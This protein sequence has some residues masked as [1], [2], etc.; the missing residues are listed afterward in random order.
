MHTHDGNPPMPGRLGRGRLSF[1]LIAL[2][3]AYALLVAGPLWN[4]RGS[5]SGLLGELGANGLPQPLVVGVALLGAAA[6]IAVVARQVRDVELRPYASIA[7]VLTVFSG[8]VLASLRAQLPFPNISGPQ[9]GLSGLTLALVGGA[10]VGRRELGARLLGWTLAALPTLALTLALTATRGDGD[11]LAMFRAVAAPLRAY[12]A[13]LAVSSLL[14]A[15]LG[16]FAHHLGKQSQASLPPMLR[17][18]PSAVTPTNLRAPEYA[19]QPQLRQTLPMVQYDSPAAFAAS[20]VP[21]SYAQ[22]TSPALALDDP[23]LLALTRKPSLARF[24]WI[25][26]AALGLAAVGGYFLVLK[27]EQERQAGAERARSLRAAQARTNQAAKP[28]DALADRMARYLEEREQERVAIAPVVT[29]LEAPAPAPVA[30]QASAP[31][32]AKAERSHR[33]HHRHHARRDEAPAKVEAKLKVEAKPEPKAE[34]KLAAKS[35]PKVEPKVEP[36]KAAPKSEN[37]RELDL[38]DLLQK[39]L[40][41]GGKNQGADDPILGL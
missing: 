35:E 22:S 28:D 29:P 36:K 38:D 24:A 1:T 4:A 8:L 33:H 14:L 2:A 37:E 15:M 34:P 11:P 21:G 9:L 40:K 17:L 41:G 12:L 20:Y 26:A 27:P 5:V 39:S 10:L 23:D 19:R 13:L 31:E 7:P 18:A 32:E 3:A 6:L 25:A 30:E 16:Q